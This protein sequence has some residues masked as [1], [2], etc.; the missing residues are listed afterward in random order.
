MNDPVDQREQIGAVGRFIRAVLAGGSAGDSE[1]REVFVQLN[2]LLVLTIA[3]WAWSAGQYGLIGRYRSCWIHLAMTAVLCGCWVWG[4]RQDTREG[5]IRVANASGAVLAAG[6]FAAALNTEGVGSMEAWYL[7]TLPAWGIFLVSEGAAAV[8]V[9]VSAGLVA[10]LACIQTTI[11]ITPEFVVGPLEMVQAHVV[12]TMLLGLFAAA[13]RRSSRERIR[14]IWRQEQALTTQN[15]QLR[16]EV[17][18]RKLAQ[19]ELTSALALA[20]GANQSKSR[21]LTSVSHE[22]R[23][24]LNAI[25]G[26]TELVLDEIEDDDDPE[27]LDRDI[28]RVSLASHH[29]LNLINELLDLEKIEV[30]RLELHVERFELATVIAE[31]FE[32]VSA[33]AGVRGD[34]LVASGVD[35]GGC[36]VSDAT[37]VAQVVLNIV[38]NAAKFTEDGTVTIDVARDT[39]V[40][41]RDWVTIEISDD[42]IGMSE[43]QVATAFE[44]FR[45]ATAS[46]AGRV[47]G[48]GLGLAIT[49]ELVE[50]LGGSIDLRSELDVG[51]TVTIRLPAKIDSGPISRTTVEDP[52]PSGPD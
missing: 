29:L 27:M 9:A 46:S 4:M 7:C 16:R 3:T 50:L 17:A 14:T 30:G 41:G 5:V 12:M 28:G 39:D 18:K 42:G 38:S 10:L 26:Y 36:M 8:W 21:F 22:L 2:F 24:P 52:T 51:M 43:A 37:R 13:A 40:D 47:G 34:Q 32:T 49:H 31:V 35:E 11:G 44:L 6:L 15:A 48:T 25:L 1:T 33:D 23:T 20:D 19:A 45:G